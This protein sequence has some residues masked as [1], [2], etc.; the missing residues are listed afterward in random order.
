[1]YVMIQ[2]GINPSM[3]V[4]CMIKG[5]GACPAMRQPIR[6][7]TNQTEK[8]PTGPNIAPVIKAA[9]AVNEILNEGETSR[10]NALTNTITAEKTAR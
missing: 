6:S 8:P 4:A 7:P 5:F 10:E 2:P 1:M 9:A 3:P